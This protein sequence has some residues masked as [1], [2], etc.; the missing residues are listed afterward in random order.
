MNKWTNELI[1]KFSKEEIQMANKH[2][3][4]L[5]MLGHKGNENQNSPEIPS[6][7]CQNAYLSSITKTTTNADK[8]VGKRSTSILLVEM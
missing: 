4:M 8:D 5:N 3:E 6:H 1:R 7:P 2:E